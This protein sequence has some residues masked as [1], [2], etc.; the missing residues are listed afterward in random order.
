MIEFLTLFLGLV[1]GPKAVAVAVGDEVAAVEIV[2]DGKSA[3][4]MKGEPWRAEIDLGAELVSH[5]LAAVAR[6][7]SG[8]EIGRATQRLNVPRPPA[9]VSILLEHDDGGAV[10]AARLAWESSVPG[11]LRSIRMRLDGRELPV[12]GGLEAQRVELPPVDD[13]GFHLLEAELEFAGSV[14]ARGQVGFG[15]HLDRA[16]S[17]LTAIPVELD[18]PATEPGP[19]ALRD[20]FRRG[21]D[22]LR[23]VAVESGTAEVIV[24]RTAA[25]AAALL[26]LGGGPGIVAS[27]RS[28]GMRAARMKKAFEGAVLGPDHWFRLFYP[29]PQRSIGHE[30]VH[31]VFPVTPPVKPG[32]GGIYWHAS[33]EIE[34]EE[35]TDPRLADAVAVAGNQAATGGNRR[36]VLLLL[37]PRQDEAESRYSPPEV[38]RYLADLRV[39]LYV[40]Y[41]GR[42]KH[43]PRDWGEPTIVSSFGRFEDEVE[44]LA[45][46]LDRQRIVW[47]DG[48]HLVRSVTLAAEAR[49]LK[50]LASPAL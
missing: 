11:G 35:E 25:A 37:G 27:G 32:E 4:T 29:V 2:L 49:G 7:A 43:A 12:P 16:G 45:R 5:E 36:A 8:A 38:R 17:Q 15:G 34:I 19:E 18:D 21:D 28:Q 14:R 42:A 10:R 1:T 33:P 9:E 20:W 24:V 30:M 41:L 48:A 3:A 44:A 46:E 40:W 6:D 50:L 23:V 39:P 47:V 13:D 31:E 22:P 26:R